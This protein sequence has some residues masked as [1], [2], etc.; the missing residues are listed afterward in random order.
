MFVVRGKSN[1]FGF[2][3]VRRSIYGHGA[4]ALRLES[5]ID[6]EM[7]LTCAHTRHRADCCH[8]G[9]PVDNN[10]QGHLEQSEQR[11]LAIVTKD[12]LPHGVEFT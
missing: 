2:S 5:L 9:A 8:F 10:P 7:A 11:S 1:T 12:A 4:F 3:V 6:K